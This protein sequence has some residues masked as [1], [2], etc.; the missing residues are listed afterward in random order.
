MAIRAGQLVGQGLCGAKAGRDLTQVLT[1]G[2][3]NPVSRMR[4][5]LSG[6]SQ[7]STLLLIR[8]QGAAAVR[9]AGDMSRTARNTSTILLTILAMV[10]AMASTALGTGAAVAAEP[11]PAKVPHYFGPWPNWANSPLTLNKA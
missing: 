4:F 3:A 1:C 7:T 5:L 10:I 2:F 11:D 8:V 6:N 9:G